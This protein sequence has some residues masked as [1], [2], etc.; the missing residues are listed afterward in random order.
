M[1]KFFLAGLF[2]ILISFKC[3]KKIKEPLYYNYKVA[4]CESLETGS[5]LFLDTLQVGSIKTIETPSSLEYCFGK[6]EAI[7]NF[8][9]YSNMEFKLEKQFIGSTVIQ[10]KINP[11]K[12]SK[13]L[14]N[15]RDTV[16]VESQ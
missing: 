13:L 16:I 2:I 12:P 14:D 11:L 10:V 3:N 4:N 6:I 1:Q 7:E 15:K 8:K 9:I 5:K